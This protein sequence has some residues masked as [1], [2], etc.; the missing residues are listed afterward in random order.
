VEPG[1]Y[2]LAMDGTDAEGNVTYYEI[3]FVDAADADVGFDWNGDGTDDVDQPLPFSWS[4]DGET[5]FSTASVIYILDYWTGADLTPAGATGFR[6][7]LVDTAMNRST[8]AIAHW[9]DIGAPGSG[10]ACDPLGRESIC[11]LDTQSCP[12]STSTCTDTATLATA[13]CGAT[14]T[15]ITPGTAIFDETPH[16]LDGYFEGSC[17]GGGSELI[18]TL[19]LTAASDVLLTTAV[20]GTPGLTDNVIY[21]RTACADDTTELGCNDAVD[22]SGGDYRAELELPGLAAGTY[23]VFLDTWTEGA[24]EYELRVEVTPI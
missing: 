23:Y 14:L 16:R 17:G 13:A 21:V 12:D 15:A 3:N 11:S 7:Q 10:A 19:E 1:V 20:P 24:S 8:A 9:T 6:V 2:R 4:V 18:Y 22:V 5:A